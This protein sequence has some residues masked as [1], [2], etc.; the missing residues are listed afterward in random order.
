[1]TTLAVVSR[2]RGWTSTWTAEVPVVSLRMPST[3]L[4]WPVVFMAGVASLLT[5]A[6]LD[7]SSGG[8]TGDGNV[9]G[10]VL[11]VTLFVVLPIV[12][13][14]AQARS[15]VV[16]IGT[17]LRVR[18]GFVTRTIPAEDIAGFVIVDQVARRRDFTARRWRFLERPA[19]ALRPGSPSALSD[20][21][22]ERGDVARWLLRLA[23]S[24]GNRRG[25]DLP[26]P[27]VSGHRTSRVIA[28]LDE[29][30]RWALLARAAS[31]DRIG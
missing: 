8:S 20:Q 28:E 30:H 2:E 22:S 1:M 12:G 23:R 21:W 10:A 19:I 5:F 17:S 27:W 18:S 7:G 16:S 15:S 25:P 13:I 4:I 14:A 24:L 29:W 6:I 9:F 31:D 3:A 26:V 11:A